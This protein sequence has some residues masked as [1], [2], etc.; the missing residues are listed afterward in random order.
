MSTFR[1]S[2]HDFA[3]ANQADLVGSSSSPPKFLNQ[4][5]TAGYPV[6]FK[7]ATV[8]DWYRKN[9]LGGI[10]KNGINFD[11]GI[12]SEFWMD[13]MVVPPIVALKQVQHI[14]C[15]LWTGV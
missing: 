8:D 11:S 7:N 13:A 14:N 9:V 2:L 4:Y 12:G 10:W 5:G 1:K 6:A 3:V 15:S